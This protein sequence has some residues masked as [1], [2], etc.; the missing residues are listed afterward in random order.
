MGTIKEAQVKPCCVLFAQITGLEQVADAEDYA[1][2]IKSINLVMDDAVKLYEGHVDKH[3]GKVL[4]ATFGV[5]TAHEDDPERAVRAALLMR[6]K[7]CDAATRAS[8]PCQVKIGVNMGRIFASSVGSDIKSEYTVIGDAVNIAARIMESAVPGEIRVSSEVYQLTRPVFEFGKPLEFLPQGSRKA[9]SVFTVDA[10]KTGFIKRRGIEGLQSPMVGRA[11]QL[12]ILSGLINALFDRQGST[13]CILGEA[14]VGKSR[15]IEELFTY[16]LGFSLEKAQSINWC[17]GRCSPY[18]EMLYFPFIEIIKDLCAITPDDTEKS[19]IAKLLR[20]IEQ[21]TGDR[22]EEVFPYIANLFAIKLEPHHETRIKHLDPKEIRLQTHIAIAMLLGN[23]A[24]SNPTVYCIDDLYLADSST[25]DMLKFMIETMPDMPA[26]MIMISR[27]E[28]EELFARTLEEIKKTIPV[29]MISL[30]RLDLKETK[31]ISKNL[32]QVPRVSERLIS[33]VVTKSE[34]N[35]FYLEELLKLLISRGIIFRK[36]EEWLGTETAMQMEIPY[37]IE[38]IIRARFDTMN[39]DA[40]GILSEMAVIGRTFSLGILKRITAF[41]ENAE[42]L[43]NGIRESGY[44]YTVNNDEFSFSHAL[45]REVIYSTLSARRLKELH[46][47][48]STAIEQI[49]ADR[50]PEFYELLFEHYSKTD[51]TDKTIDYGIKAGDL[52]RKRYASLE[53]T[54]YY[55]SVMKVIGERSE[56]ADLRASVIS[57]LGDIYALTG[58]ND[59]AFAMY[60]KALELTSDPARRAALYCSIADTYQRISDYPSALGHYEMA[61]QELIGRPETEKLEIRI[62]IAWVHYL[63]GDYEESRQI[64]EKAATSVTDATTVEYRSLLARIYNILGSIYSHLGTTARSFASYNRA[65]KLYELLDDMTGQGVIYNNICGHYSSRGDYLKSLEYLQRSND[66]DRKT[67]NLLAQAIST[68]NIGDTYYELGDFDEAEK[69]YREYLAINARINNKLGNGY[70]N[71]GLGTLA[72]ERGDNKNAREYLTVAAGIFKALNSR[73]MELNVLL[74][75]AEV[76]RVEGD[77]D[78]AFNMCAGIREASRETGEN[79]IA[80]SSILQQVKTKVMMALKDHKLMVSHIQEATK[81]LET[82]ESVRRTFDV[83]QETL[84]LMRFYASEVAYYRGDP[85]ATMKNHQE[86][87]QVLNDILEHLPDE[88]RAAFKKRRM[89]REFEDYEKTIKA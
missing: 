81:L 56:T 42:E 39:R 26:L 28:K 5:P 34:G 62:G 57:K 74:S 65:L 51:R 22:S 59:D 54:A 20:T 1:D 79:T 75:L 30:T 43:I 17:V 45:V 40:Q 11:A 63:R 29:V 6:K 25:L 16:S 27:Q 36:G 89:I 82:A 24:L 61:N 78:A 86:A 15:L 64:L 77:Y 72:L 49:Y 10:M 18:R 52:A 84:F 47:K 31:E 85:S 8:M 12:R 23:Y 7:T 73:I 58:Q 69:H 53:A 66:I 50:L 35:P 38:G 76:H 33:E 2:I 71:Y 68:Y 32:L 3:E 55:L 46:L 87:R 83:D 48:V 13:V 9:V 88:R 60:A 70:G 80:L 67:G 4:M 41:W 14:G 19:L 37:S 21:L 44:I